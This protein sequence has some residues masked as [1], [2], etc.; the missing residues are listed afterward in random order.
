MREAHPHVCAVILI[1]DLDVEGEEVGTTAE[2]GTRPRTNRTW[3]I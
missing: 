3:E 2:A 1:L